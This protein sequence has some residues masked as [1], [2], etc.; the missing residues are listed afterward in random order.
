MSICTRSHDD[1]PADLTLRRVDP[2]RDTVPVDALTTLLV[3]AVAHGASVG[4]I[5]A[6]SAAE[7]TAFWHGIAK[8]LGPGLLL[9]LAEQD[10]RL[11][12][13]VQLA[14]C[15]KTNGRHRA[16]VQKLLVHS[17][18]RGR[19]IATALLAAIDDFARAQALSL[20]VLDTESGSPA[21]HLYRRLGWRHA[22]AV[23]D[24]AQSP[25]GT[26]HPTTLMF[27]S[28]C[29]WHISVVDP[30]GEAALGLLHEAWLEARALYADGRTAGET[31]PGNDPAAPGSVYLVAWRERV[32][33]GCA[34]LRPLGDAG[35]AEL[36]RMF[37]RADARRQGLARA[38]LA[39]AEREARALGVHTLRLETGDRQAAAQ[40]L[41]QDCGWRP[42]APFG[43]H[44][45][46]PTS[47]CFEK[48]L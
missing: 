18:A 12:G 6:L 40:A 16:D 13:T 26:M 5:A 27:K 34:A 48:R 43:V 35:V 37:V 7:A 14:P 20:L 31:P 25:G 21:E 3:D 30:C 8:S 28:P 10:G 22:G 11:V 1:P 41:Y 36:R 47:R 46:D 4:F 19:G 45:S 42:M 17:A 24:F 38:L 2:A 9:W 32:T 23:P 44:A 33:V 15:T 29:P 39:R